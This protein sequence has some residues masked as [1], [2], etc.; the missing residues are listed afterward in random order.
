MPATRNRDDQGNQNQGSTQDPPPMQQDGSWQQ[1]SNGNW[2]WNPDAPPDPGLVNQWGY[3]AIT[4][5]RQD[6]LGN[7]NHG[8]W[9]PDRGGWHWT[10]GT[11]PDPDLLHS[12]NQD[13]LTD[14]DHLPGHGHPDTDAN[15][16]P[17][18]DVQPPTVTDEW[19][20]TPPDITGDVPPPPGGN[21]PQITTPPVHQ[22]FKV[23]PGSI[24]EAE[25]TV[26]SNIDIVLPDYDTLKGK[27]EDSRSS[28]VYMQRDR[29]EFLNTQDR[30]LLQIGDTL[31]LA[32]QFVQA[33]NY[34][35]QMYAKADI[36]S[37]V[38]Q[39]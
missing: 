32:G 1:D 27:V 25:T 3:Q 19:N 14:P 23:A 26:L 7:R 36:D 28:F 35:A 21:G 24:R 34:A 12:Y 31:E 11:T 2:S 20:G 15:H 13:E 39:T 38:P 37:F 9:S 6:P 5:I 17:P 4:D 16:V 30:I 33:L 22:P 10:W 18:P 29:E 8:S